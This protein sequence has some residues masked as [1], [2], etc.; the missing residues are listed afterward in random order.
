MQSLLVAFSLLVGASLAVPD[1][2]GNTGGVYPGDVYVAVNSTSV[3]VPSQDTSRGLPHPVHKN[4]PEVNFPAQVTAA[5][6]NFAAEHYPTTARAA[7]ASPVMN[8]PY[9]EAAYLSTPVVA[10]E[11]RHKRDLRADK[12]SASTTIR[13][14]PPS[15]FP[16]RTPLAVF[17][18]PFI[19]TPLRTRLPSKANFAAEHYHTAAL[20]AVASPV[21]YMPSLS[22]HKRNLTAVK[23]PTSTTP[24]VYARACSYAAVT[25]P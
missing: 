25:Y 3:A 15:L 12:T 23:N 18:S 17:L 5:K 1:G 9:A 21:T 2:Y 6:A 14:A 4:T 24:L 16:P 22:R 10:V 7:V 19:K 20:A 11:S 13:K 8:Y